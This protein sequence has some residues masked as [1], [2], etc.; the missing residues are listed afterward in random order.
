MWLDIFLEVDVDGDGVITFDEF[1]GSMD[2]IISKVSSQEKYLVRRGTTDKNEA[3][4]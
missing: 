2:S 4:R 3:I 1:R